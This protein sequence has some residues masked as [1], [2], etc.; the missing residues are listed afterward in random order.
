MLTWMKLLSCLAHRL[1]IQIKIDRETKGY[2][3]TQYL[4]K[5]LELWKYANECAL[6]GQNQLNS[7]TGSMA[8]AIGGTSSFSTEGQW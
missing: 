4:V 1:L 3:K 5:T 8:R 7:L 2:G 6:S